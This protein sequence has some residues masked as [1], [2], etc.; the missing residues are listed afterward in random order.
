MIQLGYIIPRIIRRHLP[1]QVIAWAKQLRLGVEPGLETRQ[2]STA[3]DRYEEALQTSGRGL[4]GMIVL[5]LGYGGYFGL[6]V[7]LLSRGARHV[8]LVDPYADID[9]RANLRLVEDSCPYLAVQGKHV[10]PS[11]DWITII[12]EE[13]ADSDF[14]QVGPIDLI[15]SSSVFEHVS[16]PNHL[17]DALSKITHPD[18]LHI[19][20]VDIRDHFFKFPF[21]MLCYSEKH[22]RRYLNPPSNLNRLRVWDY[23]NLFARYFQ[24][25]DIK[26]IESDPDSLNKVRTRVKPEFLRGDENRDSASRILIKASHPV[27][28]PGDDF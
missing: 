16:S 18:G 6:G 24:N 27:V 10:V 17:V 13:V 4:K 25:V 21:E 8:L 7:E 1:S 28:S 5:I 26:V 9:H 2:P 19:H 22:W 20:F 23:E 14:S 12:H 11:E 3:A 15:F